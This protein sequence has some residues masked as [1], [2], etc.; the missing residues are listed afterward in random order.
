LNIENAKI[1]EKLVFAMG[2]KGALMLAWGL[3]SHRALQ[4]HP[5]LLIST[6][7]DATVTAFAVDSG[8]N[9]LCASVEHGVL[10]LCG[11]DRSR[12][13]WT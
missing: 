12:A 1:N 3:R 2:P 13:H 10:D 5:A 9:T 8:E 6:H 11:E 4:K 7:G